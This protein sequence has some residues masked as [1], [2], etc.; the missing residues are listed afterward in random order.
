MFTPLGWVPGLTLLFL[1]LLSGCTAETHPRSNERLNGA[2]NL[3]IHKSASL[4]PYLEDYEDHGRLSPRSEERRVG[5]DRRLRWWAY[6][7]KRKRKG[8]NGSTMMSEAG[9]RCE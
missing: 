2:D 1:V 8:E 6:G 7:S 3:Y 4:S 5:K 9:R